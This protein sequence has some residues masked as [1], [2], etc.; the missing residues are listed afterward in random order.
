MPNVPVRDIVMYY[1]EAGA[2]DPVVLL[3]GLGGDSQAW[4]L[5]ARELSQHSRVI[6][7]DNRGAGRTSAPDRPYSIAAMAEDVFALLTRLGVTKAHVAGWSMGGMIAQE[8]ALAHPT[9]VNRL[10]LLGSAPKLDGQGRAILRSW[11][12][13]RRSN[14]SREQ[15]VRFTSAWFY[16][17]E[18]LDDEPRYERAVHSSLANPYAQQDHA[19]L[20]QANAVLGFDAS[21][22]L[23]DLKQETLVVTAK[24]DILVPARNA[25]CLARL[26]PKATLVELPGGHAGCIEYPAEYG[27][28][29]SE[30]LSAP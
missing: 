6:M 18:L 28:A 27:A 23:G 25:E 30:F 2:G 7:P 15:F 5:L 26:L 21:G 1:E 11:I 14:M 13:V 19:F 29:L 3:T 8:L 9:F 4:S 24:D 22:R 12:D 20:R 10:A 17:P 16:S